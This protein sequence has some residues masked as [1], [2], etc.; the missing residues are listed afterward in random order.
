MGCS[1]PV[2]AVAQQRRQFE[3]HKVQA[4]FQPK[5]RFN[6]KKKTIPNN[7]KLLVQAGTLTEFLGYLQG[8][9]RP[10]HLSLRH[11]SVFTS[12]WAGPP[13]PPEQPR[14][15]CSGTVGDRQ[16]LGCACCSLC[17]SSNVWALVLFL[18][19]ESLPFNV[20]PQP[21]LHC[22][23][24]SQPQSSTPQDTQPKT[25][26]QDPVVGELM[27]N[28]CPDALSIPRSAVQGQL[29]LPTPQCKRIHWR[30]P[31]SPQQWRGHPGLCSPGAW[32]HRHSRALGRC[33]NQNPVI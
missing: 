3:Y 16:V 15:S 20:L 5:A 32:T 10:F 7:P 14:G 31:S 13:P 2:A 6:K 25:L 24:M 21:Q 27:C 1:V 23:G 19:G 12:V 11:I 30:W 9:C 26:Q 22:W 29:F 17:S 33:W 8:I 18:P 28:P 4:G